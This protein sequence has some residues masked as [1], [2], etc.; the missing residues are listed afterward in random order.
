MILTKEI[1]DYVIHSDGKVITYNP[2]KKSTCGKEMKPYTH[3]KNGYQ[4]I[5]LR[6]DKKSNRYLLHRLIAQCFIPNA[7]NKPEVNHKDGDKTNNDI[8]NLEWATHSENGKHSYRVLGRK[9]SG[10]FAMDWSGKNN[11]MYGKTFKMSDE[12]KEKIGNANRG[13]KRPD[14]AARN[15]Q[16]RFA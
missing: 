12:Q 16:R 9:T 8:S 6:I 13:K 10:A 4:S 7:E 5:C 11:P 14:V 3:P 15:R 1:G 2:Y